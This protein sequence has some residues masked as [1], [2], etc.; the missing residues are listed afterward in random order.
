MQRLA[1]LATILSAATAG[2]DTAGAST[3]PAPAIQ[4]DLGLSVIQLAYEHPL[5]RHLAAS[6]SAGLFGSYFL[7]WFDLGDDVIG[8]GG[9]VRVTW[10]ARET[11]RGFYVAPYVRAH[12]VSGDHDGTH[13]TGFGFSAGAF[14]GWAFGLTERI[15]L[16]IGAGAQYLRHELDTPGGST[17]STPFVALDAL[18]GVRL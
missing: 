16:R 17:S 5:G 18:V 2:A 3:G 8:V 15:D 10:F 11:G 6:V 1:V 9:G 14:A 13:G 12:R 4:A 7:P